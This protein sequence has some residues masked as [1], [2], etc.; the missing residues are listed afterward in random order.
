MKSILKVVFGS[1][2]TLAAATN[3][4]NANSKPP[5]TENT[6][7]AY[8]NYSFDFG[9]HKVPIAY[10][11]YAN[12]IELHNYVKLNSIVPGRGGAYVLDR[13]IKWKNFQIDV[14]FNI[15][16]NLAEARGFEMLLTEHV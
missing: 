8:D 12:A 11:S 9:S 10:R 4:G 14:D 15:D 6:K 5:V 16:S 1:A 2:A 7:V 3:N 13:Q